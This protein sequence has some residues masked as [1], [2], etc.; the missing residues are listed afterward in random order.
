LINFIN[1]NSLLSPNQFGFRSGRSTSI[2]ISSVVS[3]LLSKSQT[4][5]PSALLLLDL[6]KA[7]D[8]INHRLLL[9]KLYHYG[10]RGLAHSWITSYLSSRFQKTKV[11]CN[12]S[13]FKPV[14]AGVPQ[15]SILGPLLF[16]LFIN[17]IFLLTAPCIEIYLYAD[18]TAVVFSANDVIKL[19]L[20]VNN[21]LHVYTQ[22]CKANC[23]VVNPSKSNFMLFN[24]DN[25]DFVINGVKL[26]KC[27]VVKYL[28]VY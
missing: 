10:I 19:Q 18:D 15:G 23:I 22:W 9:D 12:L 3:S 11:G 16:I 1:K 24:A 2:A 25:I 6:K 13:S 14:T 4:K 26:V 8:L 17:D 20:M 5:S 27:E 7:F 21:F 28:E